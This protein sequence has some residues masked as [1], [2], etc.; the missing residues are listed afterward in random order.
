MRLYTGNTDELLREALSDVSS[1]V[2]LVM[3]ESCGAHGHSHNHGLTV[4]LDLA[5]D[6]LDV[7]M[8]GWLPRSGYASDPRWHACMAYHGIDFARLPLGLDEIKALLLTTPCN[9][10]P[11]DPLAIRLLDISS[12]VSLIKTLKHNLS[13]FDTRPVESQQSFET[14]ATKL[15]GDLSLEELKAKV[16]DA[17]DDSPVSFLSGEEFPDV[18]VDVEGTLV[19]EGQI[20]CALVE[21]LIELSA[22]RPITIWTGGDIKLLEPPLRRFGI[23]YKI[24]SSISLRAP[25]WPQP[26]TTCRTTS[27]TNSTA[28]KS[29]STSSCDIN[30]TSSRTVLLT[31]TGGRDLR[32]EAQ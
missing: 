26:S 25:R 30:T 27:S 14:E 20:N 18:F 23:P 4:S 12:E 7:L 11:A 28:S 6:N 29:K 13:S 10:R 19:R 31:F 8:L 17:A 22:T 15:F 1:D 2:S 9:T 16:Q 3:I 5:K 24:A 21:K 32:A